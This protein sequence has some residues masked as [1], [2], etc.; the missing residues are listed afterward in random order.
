MRRYLLLYLLIIPFLA[1]NAPLVEIASPKAARYLSFLRK[2]FPKARLNIVVYPKYRTTYIAVNGKPLPSFRGE[3][4]WENALKKMI[5]EAQKQEESARI[6]VD[7][8]RISP[9][10]EELIFSFVPCNYSEADFRGRWVAFV[11]EENGRLLYRTE[12][13]LEIPSGACGRPINF[14]WRGKCKSSKL[15]F[16][17][18]IFD[19]NGKYIISKSNKEMMEVKEK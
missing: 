2:N 14:S 13:K 10:G 19:M 3:A 9:K 5:E 1:L 15:L 18:T 17:V 7:S 12:G 8:L 11:L 4:K 16:F 6:T